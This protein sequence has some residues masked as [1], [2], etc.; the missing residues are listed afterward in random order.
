M[1]DRLVAC[2]HGR[3]PKHMVQRFMGLR[4][5]VC[6]LRPSFDDNLR[7]G[8]YFQINGFTHRDRN[9]ASFNGVCDCQ[10][11]RQRSRH[12]PVRL[13]SICPIWRI[14]YFPAVRK[15]CNAV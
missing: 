11:V 14:R 10:F 8:R 3:D 2:C 1:V 6:A 15:S 9:R 12:V 5:V 13:R 4:A 7:V